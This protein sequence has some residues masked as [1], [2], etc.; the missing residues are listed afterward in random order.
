M[1]LWYRRLADIPGVGYAGSPGINRNRLSEHDAIPD[2][3]RYTFEGA[4]SESL[5]WKIH[6]GET[7]ASPAN[8]HQASLRRGETPLQMKLRH[9][10]E[11]IE[12]PGTIADYHFIIQ[13]AIDELWHNR[14]QEPWILEEFEQLCWLDIRLVTRSLKEFQREDGSLLVIYAIRYLQTLFEQEGYIREA[15]DLA[16][17]AITLGADVDIARQLRER[18]ALLDEES[19]GCDAVA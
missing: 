9:M 2:V 4:P 6:N 13:Q 14:R 17:F 8:R 15:L 10:R 7:S 3:H 16:E 5:S 19:E 18:V 11:A 1:P 12:L